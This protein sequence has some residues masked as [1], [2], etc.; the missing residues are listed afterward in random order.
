MGLTCFD[1]PALIERTLELV[2]GDDVPT[3]DVVL[4][5]VRLLGNPAAR[6][7]TWDFVRGRWSALEP[8]IAAGLAPRLVTALP[9]LQTRAHRAEVARFFRE[10]PLPTARRAL[11]QALESF[12]LG[13]ELRRRTA[14][15]LA[16]WLAGR[17][18]AG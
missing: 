5:L 16:R 1:D 15:E 9:A 4:V 11:R 14:P 17:S 13:A 18:E 7:A 6:Q 2:L 3:Q 12:D 8:R 10:H